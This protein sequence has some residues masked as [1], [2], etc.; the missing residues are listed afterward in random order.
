MKDF[1]N[2]ELA[3]DD[4]VIFR[5]PDYSSLCTGKVVSFTPQKV[6]VHYVNTWNYAK[7]GLERDILLYPDCVSKI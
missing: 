5:T 4:D 2:Q 6:R 7:P 3:V 1:L